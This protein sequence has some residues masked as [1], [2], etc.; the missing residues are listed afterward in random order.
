VTLGLM[1]PV[2]AG[3]AEAT[4]GYKQKPPPPT[5]THKTPAPAKS[6]SPAKT[7][8]P[9]TSSVGTPVTVKPAP[10]AAPATLPF[11]GLDLR[12]VIGAGVLML[13]IGFTIRV[14]QRRTL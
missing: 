6:V 9:S 12:W 5:T 2:A 11:T 1:L 14:L 7:V 8:S 10:A 13:G 4:N 3:A